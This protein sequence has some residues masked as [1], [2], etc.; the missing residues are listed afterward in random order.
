MKRKERKKGGG[1]GDKGRERLHSIR[2][3]VDPLLPFP[4]NSRTPFLEPLGPRENL[5]RD[6]RS[7]HNCKL[8]QNSAIVTVCE[9]DAVGVTLNSMEIKSAAVIV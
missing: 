7:H 4:E 2:E 9:N 1:A 5:L 3:G 6:L 8:L